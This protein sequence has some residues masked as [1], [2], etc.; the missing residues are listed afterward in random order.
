MSAPLGPEQLVH[1]S[2]LQSLEAFHRGLGFPTDAQLRW[3][4]DQGID[5]D[6]MALPWPIRAAAV[7]FDGYSFDFDAQG[8]RALI[9]RAEDRGE[10]ID[11]IAYQRRTG[12]LASWRGVAF[13]LGD[14]DQ[15]FNP[16]TWFMGGAL[17]VHANPLTW[18]KSGRDGIVIL[19]PELTYAMLRNAHRVL[20]RCRACR[21]IRDL[22]AAA[23]ANGRNIHRGNFR[24][25]SVV[26]RQHYGDH[27]PARKATGV[28]RMVATIAG[29]MTSTTPLLSNSCPSPST[30][31]SILFR[32]WRMLPLS[33]WRVRLST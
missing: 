29:R 33:V 5:G 16:A 28:E 14:Q 17:R 4:L 32:R 25:E 23:Q 13:C 3:L 6:A 21:A 11:L 19:R 15:T 26:T 18:L 8:E 2:R 31:S 20:C 7:H 12:K 1:L 22:D 27:L 9:F 24:K 30:K 10:A